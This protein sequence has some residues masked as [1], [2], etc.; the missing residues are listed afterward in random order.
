MRETGLAVLATVAVVLALPSCAG[1]PEPIEDLGPAVL[2]RDLISSEDLSAAATTGELLLIAS[3]EGAAVQVLTS[4]GTAGRWRVHSASGVV[5]LLAE[6][7]EADIE[8][9]AARGDEAYALGSHSRVRKK[10]D[11]RDPVDRNRKRLEQVTAPK[12]RDHVFRLEITGDPEPPVRVAGSFSLRAILEGDP[13]LAPFATIPGKENGVDLEGLAWDGDR[14]V[15]GFR[16]PV[17]RSGHVPVLVVPPE[18]PSR[19]ELRFLDLGGLGVRDLL[20]V[21]EGFL[22]LAG[23]EGRSPR[24]EL[25]VWDG[26]DC[27]PGRGARSCRAFVGE[28]PAPPGGKAEGLALVGV[29]TDAY[30][31]LVLY[32]GPPGG[33]PRRLRV[34]RGALGL[35]SG[36][37]PATDDTDD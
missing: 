37:A 12:E 9:I 11:A 19:Y 10:L 26:R 4:A 27:V 24:F 20:R 33:A 18:E 32:D 29:A 14:L 25:H 2:E 15:V 16:S 23:G 8:A 34:S 30:E 7:N 22:V 36:P 1:A 35:P 6:G 3:D 28:V 31:L 17:L 21:E 13:V 5:D